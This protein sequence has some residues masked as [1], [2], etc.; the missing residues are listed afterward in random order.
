M[1]GRSSAA[2][3]AAG[4]M[5]CLSPDYLEVLVVENEIV[6]RISLVPRA[7]TSVRS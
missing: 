7:Q 1:E 2:G 5:E 3:S 6:I 4:R